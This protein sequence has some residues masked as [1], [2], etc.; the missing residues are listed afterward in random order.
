MSILITKSTKVI[1]QGFTAPA[2]T[3]GM[4]MQPP[5]FRHTVSRILWTL[6]RHGG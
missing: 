4:V 5:L 1:T 6:P 3:F 2:M